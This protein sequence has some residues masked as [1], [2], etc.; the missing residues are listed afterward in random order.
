MAWP[1]ILAVVAA[2]SSIAQ[3][4]A[5][6]AANDALYDAQV[7]AANFRRLSNQ[8]R[9]LQAAEDIKVQRENEIRELKEQ[10]REV[11]GQVAVQRGEGITAGISAGREEQVIASKEARAIADASQKA[12]AG[13]SQVLQAGVDANSEVNTQLALAKAQHDANVITPGQA[14]LSAL[15]G[16]IQTYSVSG[17]FR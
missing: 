10:F 14:F 6:N 7:E 13:M 3:T 11:A 17:G 8:T 9:A 1:L 12:R 15:T 2:G 16:G 4:N 5:Q